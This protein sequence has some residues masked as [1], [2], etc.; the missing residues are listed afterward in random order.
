MKLR[1]I[2]RRH[3]AA[4]K[5]SLSAFT[6]MSGVT[7][8]YRIDTPAHHRDA[9]WLA[10]AWA[11]AGA[12][13]PLHLRGLHYALV[14]LDPPI[15]KP[16]GDL[17]LNTDDCW[18]WLQAVGNR[19]RWLGH[20]EFDDIVDERNAPPIVLTAP[21]PTPKWEVENRASQ[22]QMP[23]FDDV[24]PEVT[25]PGFATR[26]AYRLVFIGEKQSLLEVLRPIAER[27]RAEIVLPT[28]ELSTTLLHGIV[29]RAFEDGRPCRILYCSDFDPTGWHMPVEVSRKIQALVDLRYRD[30]DIQL[31]RCA[32]T[33]EQVRELVLPATPMKDSE[34]RA[35]RW[36]ARWGVEQTEIDALAT[37][38]PQALREIVEEAVAPYFDETLL[39]RERDAYRRHLAQA[40][41]LVAAALASEDL[42]EQADEM[43]QLRETAAEASRLAFAIAEPLLDEVVERVKVALPAP[44]IPT[45]NP[46][47]DR[48][49]ALFDSC[50]PWVEQTR[51][52]IDEKLGAGDDL[53]TEVV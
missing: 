40:R 36:R 1:D 51:I 22:I 6:V 18:T 50:R 23:D 26:Q 15:V 44:E 48:D 35:D 46:A 53:E 7:D 25:L 9:Q 21:E 37:L 11:T 49:E 43:A 31:R 19:A 45:P 16:D 32:L 39:A 30:L 34:R 2:I 24:L 8:P 4:H 47:G 27:V 20:I 29:R 3:C 52:L 38:R 42:R 13:R 10:D 41:A 14:S 5:A 17:Y 12:R 28:G 33:F